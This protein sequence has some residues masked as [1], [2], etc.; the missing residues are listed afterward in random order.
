MASDKFRAVPYA[1]DTILV[2][3]IH[4]FKLL[5]GPTPD[6][7]LLSDTIK[8]KFKKYPARHTNYIIFHST[9]LQ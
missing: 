7:Q 2:S 4:A 1:D 3:T 6:C 5:V 9:T 8:L